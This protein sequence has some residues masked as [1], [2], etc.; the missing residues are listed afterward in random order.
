MRV[1]YY[2]S[3][4]VKEEIVG[5]GTGLDYFFQAEVVGCKG[6]VSV[7][8]ERIFV[9]G[10]IFVGVK[11]GFWGSLLVLEGFLVIEFQ[12]Q[13][14]I[15]VRA[16]GSDQFGVNR[17]IL[18]LIF[19]C[20]EF[21]CLGSKS[22]QIFLKGRL[23]LGCQLFLVFGFFKE[24]DLQVFRLVLLDFKLEGGI[25]NGR[26][27]KICQRVQIVFRQFSSNF[28]E[29]QVLEDKFFSERKKLKVEELSCQE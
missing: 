17:V 29:F 24:S 5:S 15:V 14:E 12:K 4:K 28:G 1:S 8:D 25:C 2:G 3:R 19:S 26:G 13:R 22:F 16:G 20:I 11:L 23:E 18:S 7:Q 27:I 21:F 10:D 9:F 6:V